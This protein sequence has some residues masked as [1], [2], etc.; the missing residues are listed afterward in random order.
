M[1]FL[2]VAFGRF[3]L[4]YVS[5]FELITVSSLHVHLSSFTIVELQRYRV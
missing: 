3:I 4:Y 2:E 5:L 1:A